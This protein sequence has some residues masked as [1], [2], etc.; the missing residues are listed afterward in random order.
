MPLQARRRKFAGLTAVTGIK[1][2]FRRPAGPPVTEPESR[3][4]RAQNPSLKAG[5]LCSQMEDN[6]PGSAAS[7][8]KALSNP[9]FGGTRIPRLVGRGS[10]PGEAAEARFSGDGCFLSPVVSRQN[11]FFGAQIHHLKIINLLSLLN[12][13][14]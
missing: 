13:G 6:G 12:V 10:S 1:T 5:R 9:L 7:G 2:S 3:L 8:P 11:K 4:D 14:I